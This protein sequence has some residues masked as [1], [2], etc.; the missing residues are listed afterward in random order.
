[1]SFTARESGE[2]VDTGKWWAEGDKVC[3]QWNELN[4]GEK[5]C[6]IIVLEGTTLQWFDLNGILVGNV[7]FTRTEEER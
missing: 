5:A 3:R 2:L 1:M 7:D 6:G 4:G